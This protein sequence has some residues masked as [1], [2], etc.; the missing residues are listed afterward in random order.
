MVITLII[1]TLK[2][3]CPNLYKVVVMHVIQENNGIFFLIPQ[4]LVVPEKFQHILRV[5]NTNIDGRRKI[6]FA[7]TSIR[8]SRPIVSKYDNHCIS[9]E[10]LSV[11]SK[12]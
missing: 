12:G 10:F 6:P 9:A 4:S 8:V 11:L 2:C 5:M 1:L 7:I 3:F